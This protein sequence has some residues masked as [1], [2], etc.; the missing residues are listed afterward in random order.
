M[1]AS[2][3]I[4]CPVLDS[5]P[6]SVLLSIP[7]VRTYGSKCSFTCQ[8]GYSSLTGNVTRTC[9]A[10]GLWSGNS[11]NC[12]GEWLPC[13]ISTRTQL[14]KSWIVISTVEISIQWLVQL[15]SQ[16]YSTGER[17]IRCIARAL[18]IFWATGAWSGRRWYIPFAHFMVLEINKCERGSSMFF[19]K[20]FVC[21]VFFFSRHSRTVFRC[22]MSFWASLSVRQTRLV[23]C[24]SQL[25]R[26]GCYWQFRGQT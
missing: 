16:Y 14:F 10:S 26:A 19:T 21:F 15:V 24:I 23:F 25:D 12:S 5:P 11:I 6:K 8:T 1:F 3:V 17:F 2:L 18:S 7:C 20:L 4:N 13:F 9:L 22:N